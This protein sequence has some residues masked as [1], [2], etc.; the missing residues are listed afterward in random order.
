MSEVP[1]IIIEN[2][3]LVVSPLPAIEVV[4][5][6]VALSIE[7]NPVSGLLSKYEIDEY[8]QVLT[9]DS[10]GQTEFALEHIPST[11]AGSKLFLN[12][13]K[14][15]YE[16]DYNISVDSLTWIGSILLDVSDELQIYYY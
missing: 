15:A 16:E 9:I 7:I 1:V 14:V 11:P 2:D 8:F 4:I 3:P 5:E 6:P 12:G 10:E 13:Q